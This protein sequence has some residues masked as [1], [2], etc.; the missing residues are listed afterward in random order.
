MSVNK[1]HGPIALEVICDGGEIPAQVVIASDYNGRLNP[2]AAMKPGVRSPYAPP[3][4]PQVRRKF[5]LLFCSQNAVKRILDC[6]LTTSRSK[7]TPFFGFNL[8]WT[9]AYVVAGV[10]AAVYVALVVHVARRIE[11]S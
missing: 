1:R 8:P 5:G 2:L 10:A 6:I 7:N 9:A 3:L 4:K 11:R